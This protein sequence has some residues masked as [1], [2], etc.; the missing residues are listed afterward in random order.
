MKVLKMNSTDNKRIAKNTLFLYFRMMLIMFVTLYTSRVILRVLGVDDYGIY[1][2]VGGVVTFLAFMSNALGVGTSRFIIYE[3]GKEESHLDILFSTVRIAHIVLGMIIIILGEA[4]GLW[5]IRNKL[6]IP[7]GR[8]SAALFTF[9]L[10]IITVFFQV[11][12]VPYNAIIIAYEKMNVYALVSIAEAVMRLAIVYL[13]QMTT[14]DKLEVYSVLYGMVT[15][16]VMLF[17]RIYCRQNF[18]EVKHALFFDRKMFF[19]VASFSGWSL[20]TSSA[21]AFANQGVTVVTNM[22]FSPAIVTVRSLALTVNKALNQFTNSFRTAVNPQ[23]VKKY[24]SQD[25]N[26]S[27]KLALES[28]KYTFYLMLVIVLPIYLLVEPVL[29]IWLGQMPDGII[30]FVKL[31]LIQGLFQAFDTSLYAPIYAKGKIKE[32]AIISPIFDFIQLPIVYALFKLGYAPISLA[33]VEL[34]AY[35]ALGWIVKPILVHRIVGYSIKEIYDVMIQSLFVTLFSMI[36]PVIIS[37]NVDIN[38]VIGFMIVTFVTVMSVFASVWFLGVDKRTKNNFVL[39][40]RVARGR[41]DVD[42]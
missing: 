33:W 5:F 29:K 25:Y 37:M 17:Y 30:P 11:T 35:V 36:I 27:K 16:V 14:L 40:I 39:W 28:T 19:S 23:I 41:R 15:I 4:I 20:I 10:S 38:S 13:L 31:A 12:Q 3:I 22:F 8:M 2:T 32:N 26:G 34:L 21:S 1:Q 24:A 18:A 9:Q 7:P 42:R 6:V